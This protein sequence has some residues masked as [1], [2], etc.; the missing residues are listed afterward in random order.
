MRP[1][2]SSARRRARRRAPRPPRAPSPPT[3][4]GTRSAFRVPSRGARWRSRA[5]R[6]ARSAPSRGRIGA[7]GNPAVCVSRCSS[8]TAR[9]PVRRELGHEVGDARRRRQRTVPDQQPRGTRRERLGDREDDV[10]A[11]RPSRRR[12]P[13]TNASPSA[14]QRHLARR[15]GRSRPRSTAG[16]SRSRRRRPRPAA[17]PGRG[18]KLARRPVRDS[19]SMERMTGLDAGFL[20]M[21]TPTLHMH[22]LKISVVDPSAIPGRLLVRAVPRGAVEAPAP[23]AAVPPPRRRGAA[24]PGPPRVDRGRRVR[25]GQPRRSRRR[26][27]PRRAREMD[28]MI[29]RIASRPA[30]PGPAPVADLGDRGPGGRPGVLRRQDPP[31]RRGRRRRRRAAGERPEPATRSPHEPDP[32]ERPWRPDP[33]PAP[34]PADPGRA[35]RPV[36]DEPARM[37]ALVRRTRDNVKALGEHQRERR[38]SGRPEPGEGHAADLVQRRAHEAPGLRDDLA[39]RWRTS[40]R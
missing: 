12:T 32:P 17:A 6:A 2:I 9:L 40:R 19:E 39:G 15:E 30:A 35:A 33:M 13:R 5:S 22:T 11:R 38:R 1:A 25:P 8:V 7:R 26:A 3:W 37:P 10:P 34:V 18:V 20:Y 28:E 21:E 24:R 23:A 4:G 27:R 14:R 36:A 31:R 29:G 16:R